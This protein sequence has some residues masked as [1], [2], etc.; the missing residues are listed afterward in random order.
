MLIF[1][2]EYFLGLC[3]YCYRFLVLLSFSASACA[4]YNGNP[5]LPEMPEQGFFTPRDNALS[6]KLGYEGD[7]MLGRHLQVPSVS[8]PE[9]YSQF[10]AASLTVGFI[11]RIEV[12]ALLGASLTQF[13][14]TSSGQDFQLN[15]NENFA[16]EAGI[17]ANTPIW[18]DLK[19]GV[20][21][22]YFYA[23]PT[24]SHGS[25]SVFQ[26]EWQ[27][28]AAFSQTF[29]YFTP[30]AGVKFGKFNMEYN[31]LSYFRKNISLQNACP[32]G[33]FLG[34]GIS[35]QKGVYLDLEVRFVDEY[36][37]TGALGCSF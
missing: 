7:F 13:S 6:Y 19:F 33:L 36:A 1:F 9:I 17:R 23:W 24:L 20:D 2:V 11:N 8:A 4:L 34:M 5:S 30:Y 28:G 25:G 26:K 18:G 29:A 35:A 14:F 31:D 3:M 27:V 12:Y 15:T 37:L 10:N 32:V 16:G 21:A 22:K